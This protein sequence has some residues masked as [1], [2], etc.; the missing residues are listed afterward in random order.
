MNRTRASYR[1]DP[2]VPD[3]PDD[4]PVLFF[5]GVCVLCSGFAQFIIRNDPER[6]IR[7][8]TAQSPLGQA[9]YHHY[10]LDP[11]NFTTNLLI[12]DGRPY[13]KSEAFVEAMVVLGGWRALALLLRICPRVLRDAVYGPIARNRYRWFGERDSCYL[14]SP[15]D[16]ERFLS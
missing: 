14:P 13:V 1:S 15:A 4:R 5:D 16:K 7:L 6:R 2:A 8:A 11:V 3:F 10:G 9:L 12:R